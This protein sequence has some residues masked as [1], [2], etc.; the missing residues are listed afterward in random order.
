MEKCASIIGVG[1]MGSAMARRLSEAGFRLVLWNRTRAKAEALARELGAETAPS[2]ME[3]ARRCGVVHIVVADDEASMNVIAGPGGLLGLGSLEGVTV[4]N[5]TTVTPRHSLEAMGLVEGAGGIYV[6]A[7]V[8]GNPRNAL[9]GELVI[10]CA[11]RR[12]LEACRAPS[13]E[14]LGEAVYLGEPPA[15]AAAK[16]GFNI[17]FLGVVAA[18]GEAFALAEAYGVGAERFAREVLGRTWLRGIVERYG[19]RLWPH[20]EASFA[21]RLAGKDARYAQRA[22]QERGVPGFLAAAVAA[23]YA[24]MEHEGMGEEDYPAVA[25]FLAGYA[26]GA[27]RGGAGG[28]Q[29]RS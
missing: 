14:A 21:A 20:G 11:A 4:Y 19:E 1:R 2:P 7:P 8:A 29:Q 27:R 22:L 5:H 18:L 28:G 3:T 25:G 10:L 24:L 12:G 23:Y 16:L 13:L 6:E 9:R 26:M 15:A 17:S